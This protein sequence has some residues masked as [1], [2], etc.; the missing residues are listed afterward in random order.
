MERGEKTL[1][2]RWECGSPDAASSL[3]KFMDK[4][5]FISDCTI[6]PQCRLCFASK[7]TFLKVPPGPDMGCDAGDDPEA[8]SSGH[9]SRASSE[10]AASCYSGPASS[11]VSSDN[12]PLLK[13]RRA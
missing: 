7:L 11:T 1:C 12:A 6:T 9:S 10:T 13:V 8:V 5:T 3:A 4:G 2:R